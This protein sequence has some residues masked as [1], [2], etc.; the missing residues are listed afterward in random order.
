[1]RLFCI[2]K[3][4][5][6]IHISVENKSWNFYL[7][8]RN[9]S[10][11]VFHIGHEAIPEIVNGIKCQSFSDFSKPLEQN[12]ILGDSLSLNIELFFVT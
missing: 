5:I 8:E 1:M 4:N 2:S 10:F 11:I 3:W 12:F 9:W 6:L 7:L